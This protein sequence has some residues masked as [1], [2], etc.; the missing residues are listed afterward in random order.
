M[1]VETDVLKYTLT[2]IFLI[3]TEEKEVHLVTFYSCTFKIT[4]LNYNIY[5]KKLFV[6]FKA[7]YIWCYYLERSSYKHHHRSQKLGILLNHQNFL[8]LLSK[9][10]R[11]L[12]LVQSCHLLLPKMSK[13]QARCYYSQDDLY[14]REGRAT[15]NSVNLQNMYSIFIYS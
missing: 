12:L 14:L 13:I 3:I 10:V 7:F 11:I 15:Y 4:E 8:L 9:I 1:I 6:V 5:N 2:A